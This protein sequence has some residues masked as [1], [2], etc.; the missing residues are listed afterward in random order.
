MLKFLKNIDF[1][2]NNFQL[3]FNG[4]YQYKTFTG[5]FISISICILLIVGIIYFGKEVVFKENPFVIPTFQTYK[6]FDRQIISTDNL[7]MMIGVQDPSFAYY[8]DEEIYNLEGSFEGYDMDEEGNQNFYSKKFKPVLCN[9][10][11]KNEDFTSTFPDF[12]Y[13]LALWWCIPKNESFYV[14]GFWGSKLYRITKFIL[15]KCTNSSLIEKKCKP[16]EIVDKNL[17]GGVIDVQSNNFIIDSKNL[18]N[19]LK[20]KT[21]DTWQ[22]LNLN[23][24]IDLIFQLNT[25]EFETDIGFLLPE[26]KQF[27]RFDFSEPKINY[28]LKDK[29]HDNVLTQIIF[30]GTINGAKYLRKYEK[31][32]DVITKIGGLLKFLMAIGQIVSSTTSYIEFNN[33]IIFNISEY[34]K[35][36]EFKNENFSEELGLKIQINNIEKPKESEMKNDSSNNR[37]T[38]KFKNNFNKSLNDVSK[39]ELSNQN[40]IINQEIKQENI[41]KRSE[42]IIKIDEH[43]ERNFESEKKIK[44]DSFNNI[45]T[46][47]HN[48]EKHLFDLDTSNNYIGFTQYILSFVEG[49][50]HSIIGLCC[51]SFEKE[52]INLINKNIQKIASLESIIKNHFFIDYIKNNVSKIDENEKLINHYNGINLFAEYEKILL[53]EN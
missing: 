34:H 53:F 31:I 48:Q 5:S 21:T 19:P 46:M 35:I 14:E 22:I 24:E 52:K 12:S 43:I 10:I 11:Y 45:K 1:M 15:S 7:F 42:K 49:L 30:Q 44:I 51:N 28:I 9:T 50:Y 2:G 47:N 41:N 17:Q 25:L 18:N 39:K 4:Q 37:F 29:M 3:S 23:M 13:N 26:F 8:V 32:Q 20:K 40:L 33:D 6:N 27:K 16:E 38:I 36:D